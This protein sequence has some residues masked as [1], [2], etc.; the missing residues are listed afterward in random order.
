MSIDEVEQ[1]VISSALGFSF[2]RRVIIIDKNEDAIKLRFFINEYFF[3]QV[4][5][6]IITGTRNFVLVLNNQR[7]YGRDCQD[8]KWHRHL[9]EDPDG[10]DFTEEGRREVTLQ[11]FLEE[12]Q[13]I[14]E[15]KGLL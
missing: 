7:L 10:H 9:Y 1:E 13:E 6:N 11:E 15:M 3:I 12:V 4:Y 5:L 8:D 14:I 2:V